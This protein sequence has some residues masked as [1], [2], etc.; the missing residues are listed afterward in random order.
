[1]SSRQDTPASV[2]SREELYHAKLQR[3]MKRQ[4]EARFI[5]PDHQPHLP[6]IW[7]A[8]V[9]DAHGVLV[10][11]GFFRAQR[12]KARR[13]RR[14]RKRLKLGPE[15]VLY[16]ADLYTTAKNGGPQHARHVA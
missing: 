6:R 12:L 4:D 8:Y 5:D 2:L 10:L 7:V 16:L 3:D 14:I 9:H 13:I 15:Q 1:M 11:A